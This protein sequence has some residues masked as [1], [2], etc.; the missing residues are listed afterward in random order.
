[1]SKRAPCPSEIAFERLD[2]LALRYLILTAHYRD[3]LNF[4]WESLQ[5]AQNA[6]N[7]LREVIRGWPSEIGASEQAKVDTK[8]FWQQFLDTANN[9]LNMPQAVGVLWDMVHSD[10]PNSS[11]SKTILEMDKILGLKLNEYLGKSLKLPS[12]VLELVEKREVVRKSGDFQKSDELR[13]QIEKLGYKIEDTETGPKV[14][15]VF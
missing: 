7:K 13:K 5:G 3:K 4:T 8:G 2:P 10:D 1:V 15:Q 14:K 11:K 9:D 6:L 12:Q